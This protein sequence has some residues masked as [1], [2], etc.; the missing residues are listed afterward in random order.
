LHPDHLGSTA[1]ATDSSGGIVANQ[2]YWDYSKYRLGSALPTDHRFTGQK[3][4]A[5]GL[6]YYGARYYDRRGP[7]GR[8]TFISPDT[9]VPD[10]TNMWDY[11]RFAYARLNPLKYSDPTGHTC[12]LVN[13]LVTVQADPG[14]CS[15]SSIRRLGEAA[16]QLAAA[17]A[18][19][20]LV[21]RTAQNLNQDQEDYVTPDTGPA[22]STVHADPLP[23]SSSASTSFPLTDGG[24]ETAIPPSTAADHDRLDVLADPLPG[25]EPTGHIYAS[26]LGTN[27]TIVG[28]KSTP[29]LRGY[30]EAVSEL[31]GGLA[32]AQSLYENLTGGQPDV[33]NLSSLAPTN[34]FIQPGKIEVRF[35]PN[36]AS[37]TPVIEVVNHAD[38]TYEKIH[39]VE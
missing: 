8:G 35:R 38:K 15:G 22:G 37:G 34:V 6:M 39:F 14:F 20:Y 36:S 13:P 32:S 27:V 2:G 19:G 23:V 24:P 5:T 21:Y 33:S 12:A 25:V 9:L 29:R 16:G 10:P 17:A 30:Q 1:Q 3:L 31:T 18:T 28:T 7:S 26:W 11:N 4:D